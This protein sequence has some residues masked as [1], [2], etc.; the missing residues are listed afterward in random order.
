[1]R[2]ERIDRYIQSFDE[3]NVLARG[4][5]K[6]ELID[7]A[8]TLLLIAYSRG[9]EDAEDMLDYLLDTEQ[10]SEVEQIVY[11]KT[12]GLTFAQRL[13]EEGLSQ[14]EIARVFETE[15]HRV[16][17]ESALRTAEAIERATG[18]PVTKTWVTVKDNRVRAT[19]EPLEGLTKALDEK[20]YTIDGDEALYPGGFEKASSNINCRCILEFN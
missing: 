19:H 4:S 14:E 15:F 5:N 17:N 11:E 12:N 1:M 16:Y 8:E 7:N 20:F 18:R 3:L 13:A 6:D 2:Q 10:I 9:R